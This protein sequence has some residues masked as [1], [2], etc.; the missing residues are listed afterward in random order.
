MGIPAD[1]E[2][3]IATTNRNFIGRMGAKTSKVYLASPYSAARAAILGYI[4]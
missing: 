2:V 3:A 1:G 4:G